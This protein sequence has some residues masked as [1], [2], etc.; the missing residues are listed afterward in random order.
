MSP[1]NASDSFQISKL[2]PYIESSTTSHIPSSKLPEP[3]AV[4]TDTCCPYLSRIYLCPY[5]ALLLI[6]PKAKSLILLNCRPFLP[7]WRSVC[8]MKN[9]CLPFTT[10]VSQTEVSE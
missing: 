5:V 8:P 9:T 10:E 3:D 2:S 4:R 7:F 1:G 6:L